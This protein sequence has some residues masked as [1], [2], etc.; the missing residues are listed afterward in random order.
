MTHNF[1]NELVKSNII[2]SNDDEVDC[3]AF[4]VSNTKFQKRKKLKE[5]VLSVVNGSCRND[6]ILY[7]TKDTND[8][9]STIIAYCVNT[10]PRKEIDYCNLLV[11][12]YKLGALLDNILKTLAVDLRSFSDQIKVTGLIKGIGIALFF[13]DDVNSTKK[14]RDFY[15]KAM[16][17]FKV[18]K[19]FPYPISQI[20]RTKKVTGDKLLKVGSNMEFQTFVDDI[21]K[22]ID[23]NKKDDFIGNSYNIYLLE[24]DFIDY[25]LITVEILDN[26]KKYLKNPKSKIK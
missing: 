3:S 20:Y 12:Y 23:Q 18:F 7:R 15:H 4:S 21:K 25:S 19:C 14:A 8:N 24:N 26:V 11:Y 6:E 10:K 17:V 13:D 16:R 9:I 1:N 5:A 2:F 22:N